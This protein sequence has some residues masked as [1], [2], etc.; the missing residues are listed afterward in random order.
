MCFKREGKTPCQALPR[1]CGLRARSA[2]RPGAVWGGWTRD[3]NPKVYYIILYYIILYYITLYY[4]TLYYIT[5]YY[6]IL[7]YIILC[8]YIVGLGA[9]AMGDIWCDGPAPYGYRAL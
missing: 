6:I 5:L 1:R 8:H 3:L 2:L 4:I 9:Q 7:Y